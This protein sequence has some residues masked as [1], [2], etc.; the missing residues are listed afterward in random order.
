MPRPQVVAL[1]VAVAMLVSGCGEGR[2]LSAEELE[3][4]IVATRDRV[5]FALARIT[6]AESE[7]ELLARMDE[8]ADTIDAAASDLDG[9]GTPGNHENEIGS[10]VESLRQLAFDVQ[11]TADQIRQ[12]GFRDLL[13]GTK[14]LSF[15]SWDD[16][17]L[18]LAALV[19][20]GIE[21]APLERH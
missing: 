5:D 4:S 11:A 12:P 2:M 1:L 16:V 21:V 3:R 20:K 6:Q 19:R 8:A 18:A 15:E 10:L 7:E 13:T 14:G 17:N 9:I